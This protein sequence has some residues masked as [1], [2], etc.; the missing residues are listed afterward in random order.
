MQRRGLT[1]GLGSL[2]FCNQ[3]IQTKAWQVGEKGMYLGS[4]SGPRTAWTPEGI[5]A[6]LGATV[7]LH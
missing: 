4:W 1:V 7:L 2:L 6:T 3:I 5:M